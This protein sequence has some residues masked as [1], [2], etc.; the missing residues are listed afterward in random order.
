MSKLRRLGPLVRALPSGILAQHTVQ[1]SK[2][3]GFYQSQPY[4]AW[5]DAVK[6]RAGYR[7]EAIDSAGQRCKL[8]A[9]HDRMYADHIDEIEDGGDPLDD[10]NGQCLCH[11]HHELKKALMRSERARA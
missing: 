6:K 11:S 10:G 5:R 9:P 4:R 7:C 8:R 1:V 2:E 3:T